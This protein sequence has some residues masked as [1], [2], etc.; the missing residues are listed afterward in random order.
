MPAGNCTIAGKPSD[1]GGLQR[2]APVRCASCSDD[3]A[4][5]FLR[6]EP[7][8]AG[9]CASAAFLATW[10]PVARRDGLAAGV[11]P[12]SCTFDASWA[13]FN[14]L[15]CGA[16]NDTLVQLVAAASGASPTCPSGVAAALNKV[17]RCMHS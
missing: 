12:W 1:A 9:C 11:K 17:G 13:A 14:T 5:L 7:Q 6:V 3:Q 8:D 2:Y 16:S 15:L 10:P 4:I